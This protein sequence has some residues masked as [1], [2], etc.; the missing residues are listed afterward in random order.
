MTAPRFR[1]EFHHIGPRNYSITTRVFVAR[2]RPISDP[3]RIAGR[4]VACQL[5][6]D[7]RANDL[8]GSNA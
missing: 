5:G 3:G 2:A 7:G 8:G 6:S 4:C 1:S